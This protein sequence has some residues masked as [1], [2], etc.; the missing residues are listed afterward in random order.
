MK[1]NPQLV[2][3]VATPSLQTDPFS[4]A[5]QNSGY[6]ESRIILGRRLDSYNGNSH[7]MFDIEVDTGYINAF[8]TDLDN[9]GENFLQLVKE[10]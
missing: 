10:I 2:L 1:C 4:D 5:N 6:H 3:A 8:S 7:Q 9:I